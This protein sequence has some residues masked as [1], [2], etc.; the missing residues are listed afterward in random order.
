MALTDKQ[1]VVLNFIVAEA[2]QGHYHTVRAG[3]DLMESRKYGTERISD[4]EYRGIAERLEADGLIEQFEDPEH[5]GQR[6][7]PAGPQK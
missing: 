6:Y 3:A 7:R 2:S 4:D 5:P 1:Q